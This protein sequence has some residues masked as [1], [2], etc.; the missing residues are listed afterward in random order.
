MAGEHVIQATDAD[1]DSVVL[2]SE[3]PV[4]V[5][6][7]TTWCGPCKAIAPV[8][9]ELAAAYEKRAR[10]VKVNVDEAMQTGSKYGVM[11]VPTLLI[12]KDGQ[13]VDQMMGAAPRPKLQQFLEKHL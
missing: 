13:V 10:I 4:L 2:Q 1:F 9:E 11:S 7:Y 5:D 8:I 12:F 6:F 3:V